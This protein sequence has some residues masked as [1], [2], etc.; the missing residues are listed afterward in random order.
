MYDKYYPFLGRK[1]LL[2]LSGKRKNKYVLTQYD[3]V[4]F[5]LPCLYS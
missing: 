5:K 4:V 2:L 1:Y 3:S